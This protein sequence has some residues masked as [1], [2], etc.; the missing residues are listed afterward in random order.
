MKIR[1]ISMFI[2]AVV[3]CNCGLTKNPISAEEKA[4]VGQLIADKHYEIVSQWAK[5]SVSTAFM[6]VANS[7]ILQ[8]GSTAGNI[9]LTGNNNYVR[10][11]NDSVFIE[12]PFFGERQM[13]GGYNANTGFSY[14]GLYADYKESYN[15]KKQYHT[16]SFLVKEEPESLQFNIN[17]YASFKTAI[18][19]RSSHRT[20]ISY[21][22]FA[23][24]VFK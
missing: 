5:P 20:F 11:K 19:L 7:G 8:P 9:S 6:Q 22:G 15:D 23:E 16:V 12:L 21:D 4:K 17:I 3:L 10:I 14:K 24:E 1:I 13:G 2:I 18:M